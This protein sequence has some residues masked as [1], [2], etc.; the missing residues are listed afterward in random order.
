MPR[1]GAEMG[2][3][4]MPAEAGIVER[5]GQLHQGLLHRPGDRRPPALQGQAEP[6]PA[7][8]AAERPGA[9]PAPPCGSARRRSARSAAPASPPP[10]AR[11]AWRSSAARPSRA[12]ELAVG[13]DGVTARCSRLAVRLDSAAMGGGEQSGGGLR[14]RRA[15]AG[16]CA[17]AAPRSTPTTRGP[18]R[19]PGSASR[20][21]AGEVKVQPDGDRPRPRTNQQIPQN[22][23]HAQ[24]PI[25]TRAPLVVVFVVA[26]LTNFDSHLEVRGPQ[27]PPPA[28]SSPTATAPSRPRCPTGPYTLTAADIPGARPAKLAVGPYRAS[29][30]NDVLLP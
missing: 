10:S 21:P 22:Q 30:Q 19:R 9:E 8:A 4:T 5:R 3:E 16:G 6:P 28:R 24:P 20:S 25:R 26:N 29:S 13:E 17:A 15:G 2:T 14:P 11:S 18:R 23:R 7:G 1:F 12:T 27:A